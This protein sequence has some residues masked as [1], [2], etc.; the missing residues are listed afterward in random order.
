[1]AALSLSACAGGLPIPLPNAMITTHN[2]D[3]SN[4][5]PTAWID[6]NTVTVGQALSIVKW[7]ED[8]DR[9]TTVVVD[10]NKLAKSVSPLGALVP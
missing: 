7:C 1:M 5:V 10:P 3:C 8:R 2:N 6:G 4:A 9:L